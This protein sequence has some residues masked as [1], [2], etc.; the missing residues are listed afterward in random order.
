MPSTPRQWPS[1]MRAGE[2]VVAIASGVAR[3]AACGLTFTTTGGSMLE[4][5]RQFYLSKGF[6]GRVGF[7]RTPAVIVI[8]MARS[9]LD[10]S[11]PLGSGSVAGVLDNILRILAVGRASGVPIFFTT[12]VFDPTGAEARGPLGASS[13]TPRTRPPSRRARTSSS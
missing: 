2:R 1:W 10:E 9:W 11:S 7:G 13:C 3:A 12:M 5:V 6:G 4:E 8:D